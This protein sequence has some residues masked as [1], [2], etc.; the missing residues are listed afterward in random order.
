[1]KN[2][3]RRRSGDISVKREIRCRTPRIREQI[4]K[5]E[6]ELSKTIAAEAA[7]FILL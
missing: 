1:M 5:C 6:L 3:F 4:R 7:I 2:K